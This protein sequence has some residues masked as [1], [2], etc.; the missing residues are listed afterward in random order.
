MVA[1]PIKYGQFLGKSPT[2]DTIE[3]VGQVPIFYSHD[4]ISGI[5]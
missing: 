2:R 3:L 1:D 4:I 5:C